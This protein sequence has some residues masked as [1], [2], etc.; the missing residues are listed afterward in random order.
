[1]VFLIFLW[2]KTD[3][4]TLPKY[5]I[6]VNSYFILWKYMINYEW[7]VD[8]IN[9]MRMGI[10]WGKRVCLSDTTTDNYICK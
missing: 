10:S 7:L 2:K 1:M 8:N 4:V 9:R 3:K 6:F 5:D